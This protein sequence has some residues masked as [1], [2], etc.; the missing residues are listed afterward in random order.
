MRYLLLIVVLL[1]M[2]P[3][4]A[5]KNPESKPL[6]QSVPTVG[7]TA[8]FPTRLRVAVKGQEITLTWEDNA[9]AKYGYAIYRSREAFIGSGIVGG[10]KVG[11]AKQG[12]QRF[13]DRPSES[14]SFFYAVFALSNRK[15][16]LA[17]VVPSKNATVSAVTVEVNSIKGLS[18]KAE[19]DSIVLSYSID[20]KS[21][22]LALYRGTAPFSGATSLLDAVLVASFEDKEGH[23]IDFPVPGVDYWYALLKE[24]DLKAGRIG[25]ILGGNATAIPAKIAEGL[26]RIGLPETSLFARTPPLPSFLL[27]RGIGAETFSANIVPSSS[28]GSAKPISP[29]TVKAIASLLKGK[30]EKISALPRLK[31]L[32]A[33]LV[34]PSGGEDYALSLIVKDRILPGKD[35]AAIEELKKYLSLNRSIITSA[36]ARYYLGIALS[37]R[38]EYREA[39]F[40]FL[41]ARDELPV[42]TSPWVDFLIFSL[43]TVP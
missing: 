28:R 13:I 41:R 12:E 27:D 2:F 9:E 4:G 36:R 11:E 42:E 34:E 35:E 39:F 31:L 3:I 10:L 22:R 18:A 38:G 29:M 16:A 43:G 32:A 15:E 26:Y 14:G 5:Q 7:S 8:P 33:E 6:A 19:G 23:F 25:F 24:D 40:E 37:R 30:P 1:L 20:G 21:S 17:T